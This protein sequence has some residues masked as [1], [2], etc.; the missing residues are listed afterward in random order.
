MVL[1][2]PHLDSQDGAWRAFINPSNADQW[3]ANYATLI[4][5]Y[6]DLGGQQGAVVLCIC[7]LRSRS[8]S[9]AGLVKQVRE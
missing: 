3:F 8:G 9:S 6:A 5:H 4:D 2:K 1:L 7:N